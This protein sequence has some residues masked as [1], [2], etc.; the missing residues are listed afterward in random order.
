MPQHHGLEFE[1]KTRQIKV[2]IAPHVRY[3]YFINILV[4]LVNYLL[5]V[6]CFISL[7]FYVSAPVISAMKH[8]GKLLLVV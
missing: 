6:Y 1:N 8:I 2:F 5:M 3:E 7:S 4:P